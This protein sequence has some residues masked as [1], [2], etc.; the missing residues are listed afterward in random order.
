MLMT[1]YLTLVTNSHNK[2]QLS[3][4]AQVQLLRSVCQSIPTHAP[5]DRN[6]GSQHCLPRSFSK[7]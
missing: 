1:T 2:L 6:A 7:Y 5:S 3:E 4:Q